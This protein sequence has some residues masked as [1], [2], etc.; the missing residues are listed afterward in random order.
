MDGSDPNLSED[1]ATTALGMWMEEEVNR[2][3]LK[4]MEELLGLPYD[5]LQQ[6][7]DKPSDARWA[8]T[9]AIKQ[10]LM[11]DSGFQDYMREQASEGVARKLRGY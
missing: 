7:A 6:H 4:I 10:N 1:T 8:V 11:H 9:D 3:V 5:V 2:R